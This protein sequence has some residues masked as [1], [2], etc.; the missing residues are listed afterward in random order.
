MA[1]FDAMLELDDA[2]DLSTHTA[3]EVEAS[4]NVINWTQSDLEMGAGEPLW[5]NVQVETAFASSGSATLTV[6]LKRETDGTIDTD[7]TTIWS[8]NAIPVASLTAGYWIIRQPLPYNVDEDAY[9][10][11]LYTIG[12]AAMSAGTVNAWIDS[13]P[14]S[15]YNTQVSAS[16]I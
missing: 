9:T 13:G 1:I 6:A 5:L 3:T 8:T 10:G 14:Q 2:L 16:N 11:L 15:S 7:S 4:T 12:T